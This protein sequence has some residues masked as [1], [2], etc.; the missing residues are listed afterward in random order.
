MKSDKK[1]L[2]VDI[3]TMFDISKS[4]LFRWEKEDGFPPLERGDNGERQYNQEHIRWLGAKKM[5]RLTRQY[6]LA[7]QAEDLERMGEIERFITLFKVLYLDDQTGLKRLEYHQYPP[8]TLK[9][10]LEKAIEHEVTDPV[11]QQIIRVVYQQTALK[12][13]ENHE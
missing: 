6:N 13:E 2:P 3:Y 4:T 5:A 12:N 9:L 8:E 10:L 11:F 1:Y 7:I